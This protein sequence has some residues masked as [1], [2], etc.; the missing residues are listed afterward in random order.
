MYLLPREVIGS[1]VI[2]IYIIIVPHPVSIALS[3]NL[4]PRSLHLIILLSYLSPGS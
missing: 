1:T 2:I 3:V 4:L